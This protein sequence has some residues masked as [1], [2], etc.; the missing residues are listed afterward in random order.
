ML[1]HESTFTRGDRDLFIPLMSVTVHFNRLRRTETT[2]EFGLE[3]TTGSFLASV[4]IA[5]TTTRTTA[6]FATLTD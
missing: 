3:V 6:T 5:V 4:V 2:T 1:Q